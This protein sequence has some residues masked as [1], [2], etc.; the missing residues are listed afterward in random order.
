MIM[1]HDARK[2]L[3]C[4]DRERFLVLTESRRFGNE[5]ELRHNICY[6]A[7]NLYKVDNEDFYDRKGKSGWYAYDSEVG[8]YEWTNVAYWAELPP[9]PGTE[10][11]LNV[12]PPQIEKIT[13]VLND[14]PNL[15]KE[16]ANFFMEFGG[17]KNE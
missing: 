4:E 12:L 7:K 11:T 16:L 8:Y 10:E 3:P 6:F 5:I 17:C 13:K 14:N 1:W 2:E 9:L 15:A